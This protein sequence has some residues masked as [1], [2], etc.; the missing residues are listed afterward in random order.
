MSGSPVLDPRRFEAI[1][2]HRAGGKVAPLRPR[3][4]TDVEYRANEAVW[5]KSILDVL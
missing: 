4:D 3:R 1:G 2:L 5:G